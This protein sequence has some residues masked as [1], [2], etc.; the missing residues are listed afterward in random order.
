M[1]GRTTPSVAISWVDHPR[2]PIASE[3]PGPLDNAAI[4]QIFS[5]ACGY[6]SPFLSAIVTAFQ[7]FSRVVYLTFWNFYRTYSVSA[8][9]AI[10]KWRYI[11]IF[12]EVY[13]KLTFFSVNL[14]LLICLL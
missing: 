11:C 14:L 1:G 5:A 9:S 3:P 8:V 13:I 10:T 12:P 7:F 2:H 4:I 6:F